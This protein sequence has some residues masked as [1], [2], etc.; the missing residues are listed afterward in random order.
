MS[1]GRDTDE[2]LLSDYWV[3]S[4]EQQTV[5]ELESE[6]DRQELLRAE[7]DEA[8][9][10][11]WALFQ[12]AAQCVALMYK[13]AADSQNSIWVPFQTAAGHITALYK[14]AVESVRRSGEAG[15][16]AGYQRR[17]REVLN[18]ARRRRHIRREELIA[19]LAGKTPPPRTTHLRGSPRTRISLERMSPRLPS[20]HHHS[21]V[22]A[23]THN[24]EP[25][26]NTFK[27]ALG[28]SGQPSI[29]V[30]PSPVGSPTLSSRRRN[31]THLPELQ[32]FI[33]DEFARNKRPAPSSSPT[34]D[35]TMDSPQHKRSRFT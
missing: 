16:Q 31:S 14:E 26:L 2:D 30:R 13:G 15:V 22:H 1:E 34:H 27:E 18:W 3:T 24:P 12:H 7:A 33:C 10:R 4:W 23:H 20:P 8:N 25:D 17:T 11:M 35:V 9:E 28:I 5:Q 6:A 19:F 29:N 21:H 32:A